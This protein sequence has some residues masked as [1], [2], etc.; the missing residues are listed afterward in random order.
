MRRYIKRQTKPKTLQEAIGLFLV[1]NLECTKNIMWDTRKTTVTPH[2]IYLYGVYSRKIT[3][4]IT[5]DTDYISQPF[6]VSILQGNWVNPV[7][8]KTSSPRVMIPPGK[9]TIIV[10]DAKRKV[11]Q[12]VLDRLP[13]LEH[14]LTSALTDIKIEL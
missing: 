1:R 10:Q 13:A 11:Y 4:I 2:R 6:K 3:D 8:G 9:R 12:H 7:E 14:G 5:G